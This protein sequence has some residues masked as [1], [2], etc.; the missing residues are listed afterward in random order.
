M[1]GTGVFSSRKSA[2]H[3]GAKSP[4]IDLVTRHLIAGFFRSSQY[5]QGCW[6]C[7]SKSNALDVVNETKA[8]AT[9]LQYYIVLLIDWQRY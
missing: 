8:C 1:I 4:G 2:F 7:R 6:V 9:P 3:Q 5:T